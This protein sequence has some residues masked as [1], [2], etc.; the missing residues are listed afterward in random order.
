MFLINVELNPRGQ[1]TIEPVI[2]TNAEESS[3]PSS[4]S[5][6]SPKQDSIETITLGTSEEDVKRIQGVPT[7]IIG[8]IWGYEL[9]NI[10]FTDGKVSGWSQIDTELKVTIPKT[11]EN[12]TTFGKGDSKQ[13]V[14]NV[15]GTPTSIIGHIWGYGLSSVTFDGDQVSGWSEI[16][17]SLN[18]K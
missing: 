12:V 7:S 1:V 3:P 6:S 17:V 11:A 8:H 18:V 9:S 4:S 15:M 13:D 2:S 16:D 14:I 10:T 5:A